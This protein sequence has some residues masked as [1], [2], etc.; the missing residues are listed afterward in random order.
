MQHYGK[1][2]T[3]L[4]IKTY[5]APTHATQTSVILLHYGSEGRTCVH[6]R[7]RETLD[8]DFNNPHN[9]FRGVEDVT[10]AATTAAPNTGS[11]YFRPSRSFF[12]RERPRPK[13]RTTHSP[14]SIP[15]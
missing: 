6:K 14:K 10:V 5:Q 13:T 1:I 12:Q 4:T 11:P 7:R 15:H 3:T 2:T 8:S 9:M